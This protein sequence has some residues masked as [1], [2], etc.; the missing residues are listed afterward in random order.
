MNDRIREIYVSA[1]RT[2][3]DLRKGT[4][5]CSEC[6]HWTGYESANRHSWK[7]ILSTKF[8]GWKS[9][10]QSRHYQ[11]ACESYHGRLNVDFLLRLAI[12]LLIRRDVTTTADIHV[13]FFGVTFTVTASSQEQQR[14]IRISA[15]HVYTLTTARGTFCAEN[16]TCSLY[17]TDFVLLECFIA[18]L[19]TQILKLIFFHRL[20]LFF[21]GRPM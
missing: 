14:E 8:V 9:R 16:S 20:L 21:Y 1:N 5:L 7:R 13:H 6:A 2:F 4:K 18:P 10:S 3:F 15:T 12:H 19:M 17:H 11:Y